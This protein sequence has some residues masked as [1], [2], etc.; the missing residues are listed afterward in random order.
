MQSATS[1]HYVSEAEYLE[2]EEASQEK[3]EYIDGEVFAMAGAGFSHNQIS[4]NAIIDIGQFLKSGSCNIYGSDL[5]V[6]V[7]TPTAYVYPDLTV[8]C[9]EP[10]FHEEKKNLITNPALIIEVLS[11]ATSDY[12]HGKKF[13]LYRQIHSFSEYLLISS[14]EKMAEHFIKNPNGSWTLTEYTAN[15]DLI[16]LKTIG[17]ERRLDVF[18]RG[19]I[20]EEGANL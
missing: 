20:L 8:I 9:G 5:K 6:H 15:D 16:Q 10:Q 4:S 2:M 12:D 3:H 11:P 7:K 1:L 14:T 19:V 13:M 18:Y 17:F